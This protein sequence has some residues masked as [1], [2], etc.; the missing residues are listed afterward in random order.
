MVHLLLQTK[1]QNLT[2]LVLHY[3]F[4]NKMFYFGLS[5]K[6]YVFLHFIINYIVL[7]LIVKINIS[8]IMLKCHKCCWTI[9][10][11]CLGNHKVKHFKSRLSYWQYQINTQGLSFTLMFLT[12]RTYMRPLQQ[13][14][15]TNSSPKLSLILVANMIFER[16]SH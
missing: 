16:T 12:M 9:S 14:Q 15:A 2:C 11:F 13:I 10:I 5:E 6:E 1:Y 3:W 4:K 8:T 7:M